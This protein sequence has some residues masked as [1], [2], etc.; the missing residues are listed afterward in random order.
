MQSRGSSEQRIKSFY[1]ILI[2][3]NTIKYY[4]HIYHLKRTRISIVFCAIAVYKEVHYDLSKIHLFL[5]VP[6]YLR[7]GLFHFYKVLLT[8]SLK[9]ECLTIEKKEY[10][11]KNNARQK[12]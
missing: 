12:V 2:K 7:H 4:H 5:P 11:T 1:F 10:M 8:P 6:N 3:F 9:Q